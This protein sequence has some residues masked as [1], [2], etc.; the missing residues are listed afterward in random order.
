[1]FHGHD[2]S[3]EDPGNQSDY[4]LNVHC[5]WPKRFCDGDLQD[6]YVYLEEGMRE[7]EE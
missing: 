1:M 2:R 7:G 5:P 3:G 6:Y 4:I